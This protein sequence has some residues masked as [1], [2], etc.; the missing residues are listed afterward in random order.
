M[1]QTHRIYAIKY[2]DKNIPVEYNPMI[3]FMVTKN[4]VEAKKALSQ[5][6]ILS[7]ERIYYGYTT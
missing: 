6:K 1:K 2:F 5:Y 3:T 4:K 7:I